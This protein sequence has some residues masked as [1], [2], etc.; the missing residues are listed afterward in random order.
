MMKNL[1]TILFISI[2]SL[3]FAQ[4]SY[5]TTFATGLGGWSGGW[6]QFTGGTTCDGLHAVRKNIYS[7]ATQGNFLSPMLGTAGGN[8]IDLTFDYKIADWSANTVG[9]P[10]TF[11]S[12]TI[13]WSNDQASWNAISVID[14][15]NHVVSGNCA[16]KSFN[17]TPTAGPLYIRFVCVYGT[18]DYYLN[19]DNINLIEAGVC[20]VPTGLSATN[21]TSN[22]ADLNFNA[23]S[24]AVDYNIEVG[25]PG[26]TPGTG[27]EISSYLNN[28]T[29]SVSATGLTA[30]TSYEFYV[31]TNCG[32]GT[33]VWSGPISLTTQCS[34]I[35]AP[36]IETFS[37]TAI[38][39]CWNQSAT[40]GGPW[41]FGVTTNPDFGNNTEPNDHTSGVPDLYAWV[42]QSG[43]DVGV[44]LTSPVIDVSALT[45][46]EL[47]FF[48]YSTNPTGSV[49]TFN[50]LNVEYYDGAAWQ[51]VEAIQGDFGAQW[52]QFAYDATPYVYATNLVKFRFRMESGGDSFDYDN[53]VLLD[54]VSVDEAPT[55]P[56]PLSSASNVTGA[57]TATIVWDAVVPAPANGYQYYLS[58]VP[59]V[60]APGTPPTGTTVDT[61]VD[62]TGLLADTTYYYYL[63]S[64]CGTD[65]GPW[66]AGGSFY[67]GYC[68]PTT[69][70]GCTDGDVIARVV[71]NTLDN[72]SG[73]GCPSGNAGYSDY[74]GD[75]TLTTTLMPSSTYNCTV[76][77]GQYNEGYAVWID[78]NDDLTFD[79]TELVGFSNGQVAG[80]GA[81]GVLGDSAT[82]PISLACNPPAGDHRMRVRAMYGVN[83]S[84]VTPCGD[85]NWG[86]IED[87]LITI[88]D[89]PSCPATGILVAGNP[90]VS[91]I[92]LNWQQGCSNAT[93]YDIEY[94]PAGFTPGTG[95]MVS[96]VFPTVDSTGMNYTL[97]GLDPNTEYDA[98][99]RASCDSIAGD[100]SAWSIEAT[101]TTLCAPIYLDT[102]S[103]NIMTCG[104]YDLPPVTEFTPSGNAGLVLGWYTDS[105]FTT[106]LANNTVTSSQ[107][108]W[109]YGAAG[110][111]MDSYFVNVTIYPTDSVFI[112]FDDSLGQF[113]SY[114]T[115]ASTFAWVE[116]SDTT[117]VLSTNMNYTPTMD[118]DYALITYTADGCMAMSE[119]LNYSTGSVIELN[120]NTITVSPNP[121]N[122]W[123][124]LNAVNAIHSYFTIVDATGRK[125]MESS[126]NG[127]SIAVDL[128]KEQPGVYFMN[129]K[130]KELGSIRILK[131]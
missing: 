42:D 18:G 27:A 45:T 1:L 92:D 11:G 118:G 44:I 66:S 4:V 73:T 13:Q 41:V 36:W 54:D 77:A 115:N 19:F 107:T 48:V 81:V 56:S 72:N 125:V 40:T 114:T 106:P 103:S 126:M 102:I 117:T 86:E 7:L 58:T 97:S 82:F 43:T 61:L 129:F 80:S 104:S 109:A 62:L 29:T 57:S 130:D 99:V 124:E 33:S 8:A 59:G 9:T 15:T 12:I 38:P 94:G 17:F 35:S 71:L 84:S 50:I 70:Y 88:A 26:F 2:L 85:N 6:A 31:Q 111:C 100:Y 63:A 53:D 79:A 128:S 52:Q 47:K 67:T 78:Y 65:V 112:V 5:N 108:V 91:T 30:N 119:C 98:Y 23:A 55:C 93:Y 16:S 121:T 21:I 110:T 95:M 90:S 89:A 22:S 60:P 101:E 76:F 64:D 39:S 127:L 37:G 32:T 113:I 74:T 105:T 68:V 96:G 10:T 69:T 123:F 87:Y 83:G 49:A 34:S 14:G 120:G 25:A 20:P 75:A 116:C 46:P 122:G 131:N 3:S 28:A 24:G 51:L